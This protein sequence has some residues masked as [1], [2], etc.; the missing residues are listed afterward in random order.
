MSPIAALA[1]AVALLVLNGLFVAA[2]FALLAARRTRLDQLAAEGDRRARAAA[3]SLRE[4]SLMLAGAQLGITICSL[5]LGAVA[6]PAMSDLIESLID[7]IPLSEGSVRAIGFALGLAIVVFL[8]MVVGE[9][10][11]KSWTISD[12][13]RSA[14]LLARPFR[15]FTVLFR[16]VIRLLNGLANLIV[17]LFGIPPQDERAMSRSSAEL[18]LML[19]ASAD[20]GMIE[21]AAH[22]LLARALRLSG[23]VAGDAMTSRD[24]IVGIEAD[25]PVDDAAVVACR[26]GRSRLVVYDDDLD[27]PQGLIHSKDLL[28]LEPSARATTTT[29]DLTRPILR[30]TADRPLDD[31]LVEM[32][33]ARQ[34]LAV[35]V[36][37]LGTRVIGLVT[38]EDVLEQL[39]GD[40]RDESDVPLPRARRD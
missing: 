20:R 16:P 23:L 40:F 35:V 19:E 30:T 22:E 33:N 7:P 3:N 27:N 12:P 14:L 11:P 32:R 34:H 1:I 28:L 26:S 36:D 4:L 37:D 17:R 2:E 9:M 39:I 38:L 24:E 15:G 31:L 25:Q 10:A 13:E 29:R 8:H 5:G 21:P 6:E 18:L